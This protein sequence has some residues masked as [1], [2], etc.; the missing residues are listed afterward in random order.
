MRRLLLA[1]A[2]ASAAR[3]AVAAE[4]PAPTVIL[5]DRLESQSSD[6]ET[7]TDCIGH[8]IVT[9]TNLELRCDRLHLITSRLSDRAGILGK[10]TGFKTMLATGH[11]HIVQTHGLRE[12]TCG[13]AEVF[14]NQDK[15]VLTE[16]PVVIDHGNGSR[17]TGDELDLLRDQRRVTGTHVRIDAP[18]IKDLGFERSTAAPGPTGPDTP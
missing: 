14:P 3:F 1:A 10:Q 4:T 18:P 7:V 16:N 12:A 5:A 2:L 9:G 6:T 8:V 17:A 13:R 15:I 11:V